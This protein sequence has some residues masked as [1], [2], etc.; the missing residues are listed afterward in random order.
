MV[1]D[2]PS[3]MAETAHRR[4]LHGVR[5]LPGQV[6]PAVS[7]AGMEAQLNPVQLTEDVV[8]KVELAILPNVHLGASENEKWGNLLVDCSDFF[9]LPPERVRVEAGNHSH[10]RRVVTDCDVLVSVLDSRQGHRPD[11][12]SAVRP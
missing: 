11:G 8:G 12:V 4:M 10:V 1:D 3:R 2:A 5:D 7:L 6:L 9:T